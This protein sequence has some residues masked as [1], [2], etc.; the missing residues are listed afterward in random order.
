MCTRRRTVWSCRTLVETKAL[1]TGHPKLINTCEASAHL[2]T[3][4][5]LHKHYHTNR[6]GWNNVSGPA[7][8]EFVNGVGIVSCSVFRHLTSPFWCIRMCPLM[9]QEPKT[10]N[11][12]AVKT[13][14]ATW[15]PTHA[16]RP[17]ISILTIRALNLGSKMVR[18]K[19]VAI[20]A[21][22]QRTLKRS[23]QRATVQKKDGSST[24]F[25]RKQPAIIDDA[26]CLLLRVCRA[27]SKTEILNKRVNTAERDRESVLYLPR[28]GRTHRHTK[29]R[30]Q[31]K[32]QYARIKE[33]QDKDS[34]RN[35]QGKI[36]Q[37]GN[38]SRK[39]RVHWRR[40]CFQGMND[41]VSVSAMHAR[42]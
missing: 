23:V 36:N 16:G 2:H 26:R 4:Q 5:Q 25:G 35:G 17:G 32:R 18:I 10:R 39:W 22:S 11:S 9:A 30:I 13:A 6:T 1:T 34:D 42:P 31:I 41:S 24:S 19:T 7:L 40:D 27:T 20:C 15:V 33:R 12:S 3:V 29:A 37:M 14:C 38:G 8:K 21:A 28:P